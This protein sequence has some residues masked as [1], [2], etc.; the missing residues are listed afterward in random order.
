VDSQL[1]MLLVLGG[2]SVLVAG[3]AVAAIVR[4]AA[5]RRARFR[6]V[7]PGW[8][9][10]ATEHSGTLLQR[11]AFL[12]LELALDGRPIV[13]CAAEA[14]DPDRSAGEQTVSVSTELTTVGRHLDDVAAGTSP[15]PPEPARWLAAWEDAEIRAGLEDLPRPPLPLAPTHVERVGAIADETELRA[16]I[17]RAVARYTEHEQRVAAWAALAPELGLRA[18]AAYLLDG[19]LGGVRVRVVAD[20]ATPATVVWALGLSRALDETVAVA[21]HPPAGYTALVRATD[22]HLAAPYSAF[23]ADPAGAAQRVTAA[24]RAALAVARPDHVIGEPQ[25][26]TRVLPGLDPEPTRWRAALELVVELATP[27]APT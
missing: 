2:V 26:V 25:H 17:A 5:G 9:R 4:G 24:A 19:E 27:R 6:A 13:V 21:A 11:G 7:F 1:V 12:R 15:P 22:Q 16:M 20:P 23:V 18:R 8:Q 10:V 14:S 3:L